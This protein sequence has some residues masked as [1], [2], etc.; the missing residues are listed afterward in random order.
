MP[1]AWGAVDN[2]HAP[3]ALLRM[4]AKRGCL[5]LNGSFSALDQLVCVSVHACKTVGV[6]AASLFSRELSA[7]VL[8]LEELVYIGC[9]RR[10]SPA[11]HC[12]SITDRISQG[13]MTFLNFEDAIFCLC[14]WPCHVPQLECA[15]SVFVCLWGSPMCPK[16]GLRAFCRPRASP[17]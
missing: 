16:W 3:H 2:T 7:S 12:T 17:P 10:G 11:P 9:F 8:A 13:W 6:P 1:T 14:W 4:C 15:I 5:C